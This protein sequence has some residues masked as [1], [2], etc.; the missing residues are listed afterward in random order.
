MRA[1][2]MTLIG[3]AIA[4]TI[5]V[6]ALV[7]TNYSG[8][9]NGDDDDHAALAMGAADAMAEPAQAG[10]S[11]DNTARIGIPS[12]GFGHWLVVQTPPFRYANAVQ[13]RNDENDPEVQVSHSSAA[14]SL[15]PLVASPAR[16]I[17]T[18]EQALPPNTESQRQVFEE[19]KEYTGGGT[20][21]VADAIEAADLKI[22]H[23]SD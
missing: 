7:V 19:R 11:R 15:H 22:G 23:G 3:I 10:S 18:S 2:M 9:R 21:T 14:L 6:N 16:S 5:S 8:Q 20:L 4:M 1:T 17:S 12:T 13:Y